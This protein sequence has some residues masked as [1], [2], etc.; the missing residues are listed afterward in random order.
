MDL[1]LTKPHS[2]M[3]LRG[4]RCGGWSRRVEQTL[5]S[6]G[7]QLVGACFLPSHTQQVQVV[8]IV[9]DDVVHGVDIAFPAG[10]VSVEE[11]H[12]GPKSWDPLGKGVILGGL[13]VPDKDVVGWRLALL[14]W[15]VPLPY[16]SLEGQ[17]CIL[18]D[19]LW[20]VQEVHFQCFTSRAVV[21]IPEITKMGL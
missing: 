20:V 6:A 9:R 13:P 18:L 1:R 7:Q 10:E 2:R 19:V 4:S 17:G 16:C 14:Y 3:S 21:V 5:L 8:E 12:C 11:V 15:G